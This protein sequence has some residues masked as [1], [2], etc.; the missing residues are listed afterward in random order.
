M[1]FTRIQLIDLAISQAQLDSSMRPLAR[2]WLNLII[3]KQ[4]REFKWPFYNKLGPYTP[5]LSGQDEYTV[6]ADYQRSDSMF[7]YTSSGQQANPIY[8]V[9]PYIFDQQRRGNLAGNPAY[10]MIDLNRQKIVLSCKPGPSVTNGFKLR[11]F[12]FAQILSLTD[13]DDNEI[14]D[15]EDQN[16]LLQELVKM[17][18]EFLDDDRYQDKRGESRED[19]KLSKRQVYEND[20]T[21]TMPLETAHFRPR[22]RW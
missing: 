1:A 13:A 17:G 11:Y 12:R 4:V 8:I 10:A 9:E 21:S 19:L 6:P 18:F 7:V 14:P 22:R 3:D 20:G 15:F 16:W 5:F 2:S